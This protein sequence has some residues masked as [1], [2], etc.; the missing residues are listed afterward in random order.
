MRMFMG[1]TRF[2]KITLLI[3]I[4][5]I[6]ILLLAIECKPSKTIAPDSFEMQ[7]YLNDVL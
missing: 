5:T 7:T 3:V 1:I 6:V 4:F 2:A